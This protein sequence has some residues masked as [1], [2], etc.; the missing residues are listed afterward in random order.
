MAEEN[1]LEQVARNAKYAIEEI[2]QGG[3][4][5][6]LVLIQMQAIRIKF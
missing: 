4:H 3:N 2:E 6:L 5:Q 1:D